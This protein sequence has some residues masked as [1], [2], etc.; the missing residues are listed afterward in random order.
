[1]TEDKWL[2]KS[3]KLANDGNYLD[4]LQD[5]IYDVQPAEDRELDPDAVKQAKKAY[6]KNDYEDLVKAFIEFDKFPYSDTYTAYLRHAEK[7]VFKRNPETV[8]RIGKRIEKMG[9]ETALARS[10][11]PKESNRQMGGKFEKWLRH[12]EYDDISYQKFMEDVPEGEIR[13]MGESAAKLRKFINEELG[14]DMDKEPDI[15]AKKKSDGETIYVA[16]EAKFL[17]GFGG[18]QGRQIGDALNIAEKVH[19]HRRDDVLG[20]AV[21]DGVHLIEIRDDFNRKYQRKIR[22]SDA[23][24]LSALYV[25]EFLESL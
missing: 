2:Q 10:S 18:H 17:T 12:T 21:I 9:I 7:D 15:L 14:I 20:L 11:Q 5:E 13:I 8:K 24:V 16:G 19:N 3:I 22:N 1:M 6:K 4:R 23:N 25:K